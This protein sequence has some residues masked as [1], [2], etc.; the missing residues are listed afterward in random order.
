LYS[1]SF[2]SP[3]VSTI[4]SEE[5]FVRSFADPYPYFQT[6]NFV[7]LTE[8]RLQTEAELS[9]SLKRFHWNCFIRFPGRPTLYFSSYTSFKCILAP[10]SYLRKSNLPHLRFAKFKL[11]YFCDWALN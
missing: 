5:C 6:H 7:D 4:S 1:T 2:I 3:V 10:T 8:I 11:P 9:G